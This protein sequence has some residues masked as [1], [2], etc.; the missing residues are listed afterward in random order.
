M[1][2]PFRMLQSR[3]CWKIPLERW[4]CHIR[5]VGCQ[6]PTWQTLISDLPENSPHVWVP[7]FSHEKTHQIWVQKRFA[8]QNFRNLSLGCLT[9]RCSA[10]F[11]VNMTTNPSLRHLG[12]KANSNSPRLS[13]RPSFQ[14]PEWKKKLPLFSM[15]FKRKIQA[16]KVRRVWNSQIDVSWQLAMD[17]NETITNQNLEISGD[18]ILKPEE[19]LWKIHGSVPL[20][21]RF[22]NASVALL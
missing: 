3:R 12:A 11:N 22:N 19:N 17:G 5:W 4:G 14:F 6:A 9:L 13:G 18:V 8:F 15:G 20:L 1:A 21:H 7:W 16:E 10:T 2:W